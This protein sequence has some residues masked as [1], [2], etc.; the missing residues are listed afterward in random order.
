VGALRSKDLANA[1]QIITIVRALCEQNRPPDDLPG[2]L[3]HAEG[4]LARV[5]SQLA[6]G[7]LVAA[8]SA[9]LGLLAAEGA[10]G[11]GHDE[12][13]AQAVELGDALLARLVAR[14][15]NPPRVPRRGRRGRYRGGPGNLG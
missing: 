2:L 13:A 5:G 8:C 12:V 4:L 11:R 7:R 9:L 10:A 1:R 6:L 15:P 3:A 14:Q